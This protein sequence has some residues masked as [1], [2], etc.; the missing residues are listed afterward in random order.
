MGRAFFYEIDILFTA[1][2]LLKDT[3]HIYNGARRFFGEKVCLKFTDVKNS[4]LDV[5]F[6]YLKAQLVIEG[7]IFVVLFA[8]FTFLRI[9]YALLLA[10]FTAIVDAFPILGTGTILVPGS[11]FYFFT[12]NP[13]TGWGLLVLYGVAILTRQLCE[14]KIIGSRLGIHPLATIFAIFAGM[15]LFGFWGII[16]GPILA[17]LVKNL[18]LVKNS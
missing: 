6:T 11:I 14:P 16:L 13:A 18:F 9:R 8:G 12:D 3:E 10:F 4:F 15:K 7:I 17:I 1:F 2:F 5:I